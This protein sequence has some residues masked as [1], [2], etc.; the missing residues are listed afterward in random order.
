MEKIKI[1]Y[2]D[3]DASGRVYYANYLNFLE[4]GRTEFLYKLGLN[5]KDLKNIFD[6]IFVV[7]NCNIDFKKP[8]FFEDTIL[9]NTKIFKFSKV[10]IIFDQQILRKEE[11]LINAK[12]SI[13][14]INKSGEIKFIPKDV[15]KL[16]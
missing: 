14:S 8:A 5:H 12:I 15:L 4:R 9:V 1:Y 16:F 10:K 6:I 3:T 2:E 11:I 7:R 13:V